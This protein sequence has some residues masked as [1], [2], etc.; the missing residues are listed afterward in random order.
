MCNLT[1]TDLRNTKLAGA[2]LTLANLLGATGF[3]PVDHEAVI[4]HQTTLPD[5]TVSD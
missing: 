3:E 5:G 4:L 2:N 1:F